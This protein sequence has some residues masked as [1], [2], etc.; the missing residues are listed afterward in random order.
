MW[1]RDR[2]SDCKRPS[3]ESSYTEFKE[4]CAHRRLISLCVLQN[5]NFDS[6]VHT[7]G[8]GEMVGEGGDGISHFLSLVCSE[9]MS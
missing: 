8:E 3:N 5:K 2:G 7:V 6:S 9:R 1:G 4:S